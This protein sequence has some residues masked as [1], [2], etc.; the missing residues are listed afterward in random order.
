MKK[1]MPLILLIIA[2]FITSIFGI[3]WLRFDSL[4]NTHI[5]VEPILVTLVSVCI[6]VW[7][8]EYITK[9]K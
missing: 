3:T 1:Q 2:S 6:F 7:G 4:T 5:S 8:L 9:K